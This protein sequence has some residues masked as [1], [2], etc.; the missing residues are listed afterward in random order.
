M[1]LV[2]PERPIVDVPD[3]DAIF[4]VV[5]DLA[6]RSQ[7]PGQAHLR[8]S[9]KNCSEGERG[10][11]WRGIYD[12]RGRV[13]IAISYNSN[14]GDAWEWVDDPCYP[15]KATTLAIRICVNYV[16]YSMTP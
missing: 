5:Y 4:H 16:V 12:E 7:I 15:E 1:K 8:E 10:A 9:C 6:D 13:M 2:F 14:M 11:H 3:D